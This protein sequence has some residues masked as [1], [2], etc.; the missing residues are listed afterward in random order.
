MLSPTNYI[1]SM[2][3]L[4]TTKTTAIPTHTDSG[5]VKAV[6]AS[7]MHFSSKDNRDMLLEK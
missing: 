2:N 3:W 5:D 4:N 1:T 7:V 6:M